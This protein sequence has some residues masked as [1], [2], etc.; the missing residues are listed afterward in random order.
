MVREEMYVI[1][2]YVLRGGYMGVEV[3]GMDPNTLPYSNTY[4]SSSDQVSLLK[5]RPVGDPDSCNTSQVGFSKCSHWVLSVLV[6]TRRICLNRLK[7]QK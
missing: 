7:H 5:Y 4:V 6:D 2:K 1:L 3:K